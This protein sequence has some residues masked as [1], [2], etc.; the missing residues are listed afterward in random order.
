[1]RGSV[2]IRLTGNVANISKVGNSWTY[3]YTS[4]Y[5]FTAA[6]PYHISRQ[7]VSEP[8]G[9]HVASRHP[10]SHV[11]GHPERGILYII[12]Y[13]A[14]ILPMARSTRRALRLHRLQTLQIRHV[15]IRGPCITS[16]TD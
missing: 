14:N 2:Y 16:N 7:P 11:D 1:M 3:V 12:G 15:I 13:P 8:Q 4:A 6:I 9:G 5:R 10:A